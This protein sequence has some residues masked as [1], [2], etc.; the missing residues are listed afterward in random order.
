MYTLRFRQIHL[1]FHTSPA[2]PGVG[3]AFSPKHWQET[4]RKGHVDSVTSFAVCHH[5]W[6]YYNT[7]V[8][9]RHPA[10]TF[11]LL[12]AQMD[13]SKAINVNVPV[14]ISAGVNNH[15]AQE[16]PE[17]RSMSVEGRYSGWVTN[18]T[19]PGFHLLCFN[20][21]YLDYL[22]DTIKETASLFPEADGIF[23]D[24][25]SKPQCC[26]R[27]CMEGMENAGLA[28][29]KEEDRLRFA[30]GVLDQY[31]RKTLAALREVSPTM[32]IFQ[33]GGNV[34]RGKR[35]FFQYVSHLE[36][37]SLPT[38]GW[39][40]DHFPLLAKY[41]KVQE[42]DFLGMTGKFH[43][44]WGEFGGFKHPNALRYECAAMLAYGSK[45]SV[46]DQ[47]HPNGALDDATYEI[48]G[49]AYA[50]VEAKEPWC[51]ETK[52]VADVAILS[53]VSVNPA[54]ETCEDSDAGASRILLEGHFLFDVIDGENVF[55]P[56]QA[57]ILP[58]DVVVNE[59]LKARLDAYLAAGGKLLLTGSSGVD[60]DKRTSLFDIGGTL[61]G[62]SE[63]CPDY[64]S[65][66]REVCPDFV[67]SPFVAYLPSQRLRVTTGRSLGLIHDPYFN[68]TYRHFCSHQHAPARPE[69]S[70]YACGS[71]K[72]NVMY[73]AHPIFT[74]YRGFGAVVYK[75][76]VLA[77]LR[78]L[79]G[80][81]IRLETNLPSTGRVTLMEQ[82]KQKRFI[83]HLLYANTVNRG[84]VINAKGGPFVSEGQSIEVIED[85][86]PL[87][88]VTASVRLGKPVKRVTLEPQGS[89]I[90]FRQEG[91]FVR[92]VL[93]ELVCHQM[94]VL[95]TK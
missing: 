14:Y 72:G 47:L 94:V 23:L 19:N 2:I 25:I 59:S 58:D 88:G 75:D 50:E 34:H 8:G 86:V 11:D 43:K 52:N 54:V 92:I 49:K 55:S 29:D 16:H 80:N 44:S 51:K 69:P 42:L 40:Y 41:S 6:S 74:L 20:T 15:V 68:R 79:L 84:G 66:S 33:N 26:C 7:K 30:D 32:P 45:C 36:L 13:A 70:G 46:G 90:A 76:Y 53:S 22:C 83:L 78:L 31:Y 73:L 28:A 17:W 89:E 91:E 21:P 1:D 56:Y 5:G 12:R 60:A 82:S 27:W 4:L 93:D 39:G 87:S 3:A 85:L 63:F 71:W 37:E 18:V 81:E 64:I 67:G 57:L 38:G 24:I 35:K 61:E 62:K 65:P 10:L 77:C 95:H 9:A 48:I